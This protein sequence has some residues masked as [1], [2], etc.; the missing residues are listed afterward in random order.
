MNTLSQ[1]ATDGAVGH[2]LHVASLLVL[3]GAF[4]SHLKS[5]V[6]LK[7]CPLFYVDQMPGLLRHFYGFGIEGD[8]GRA[9]SAWSIVFSNPLNWA[10][11]HAMIN[12]GA[13]WLDVGKAIYHYGTTAN[14]FTF[15][16]LLGIAGFAVLWSASLTQVVY[17][18]MVYMTARIRGFAFEHYLIRRYKK[19]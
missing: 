18:L 11:S 10:V 9:I 4:I 1:V 6:F 15:W 8:S 3:I 12:E 16:A 13:G 5:N 7:S 17:L 19:L 2:F 14:I